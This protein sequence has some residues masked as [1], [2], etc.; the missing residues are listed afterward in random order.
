MMADTAAV[1]ADTAPV[2]VV[3]LVVERWQSR[4][5]ELEP[6]CRLDSSTR[7][8]GIWRR[9]IEGL[10]GEGCWLGLDQLGR[11]IS[12]GLTRQGVVVVEACTV[13]D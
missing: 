4:L 1:E 7:G 10:D 8:L 9:I 3:E 13:C 11:G 6:W 12:S 5:L 2:P